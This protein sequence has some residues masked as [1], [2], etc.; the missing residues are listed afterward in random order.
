M[1]ET[2]GRLRV[3]GPYA[4][5]ANTH[6]SGLNPLQNPT[7][8]TDELDI[9]YRFETP[10]LPHTSD[11]GHAHGVQRRIMTLYSRSR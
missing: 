5:S 2:N 1:Q 11:G 3:P 10:Y 8:V 7:S 9:L 4:L 6:R